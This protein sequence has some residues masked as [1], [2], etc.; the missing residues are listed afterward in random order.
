[1]FCFVKLPSPAFIRDVL[2]VVDF[3]VCANR[4]H[5]A[6]V[7]HAIRAVEYAHDPAELPLRELREAPAHVVIVVKLDDVSVII[8]E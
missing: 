2:R 8:D 6:I 5:V 7:I 4:S 1:M 3:M